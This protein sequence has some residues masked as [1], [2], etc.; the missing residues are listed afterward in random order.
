M[1][2]TKFIL[3][4]TLIATLSACGGRSSLRPVTFDGGARDGINTDARRDTLT[5]D[6]LRDGGGLDGNRTDGLV[7]DAVRDGIRN[8]LSQDRIR[9]DGSMPD[10]LQPDIVRIDARDSNPPEVSKTLV[11]IQATPS[12]AMLT[13]GVPFS[14]LVVTGIYSDGT[15]ADLS[16]GATFTSSDPKIVKVNGRTLTGMAVGSATITVRADGRTTSMQ[17]TVTTA[18]FQIITV[19]SVGSLMVGQSTQVIAMGVFA[20][21]TKQDITTSATWTSSN[22]AVARFAE[23]ISSA[24]RLDALSAGTTTITATYQSA[25]GQAQVTVT[26]SPLVRI[27]ITPTQPI[28]QRGVIRAFQATATFGDATTSDVT[29]Q[30]TWISSDPEVV[31]IT[32]SGNSVIASAIAVGTSTIAATLG[33]IRSTTDV[34]VTNPDLISITINPNVWQVNVGGT[35]SFTAQ[36]IYS[37]RT[38]ADVTLAAT[39]TSSA[40]NIVSVSNANGQQGQVSALA[41][42]TAQVQAALSGISG[43]AT[44]T[45]TNSPL[46]SI[47]ITP[48]PGS[49]V[50]GVPTRFSAIGNYQNGTS[51]PITSQVV[52]SVANGA[53]AS[54]SNT[55]GSEGSVTGLA[56]GNTT[57]TATLAGISGTASLTVVQANLI[58]IAVNP[59]TATLTAG[60]DQPYAAV[61]TYDNNT[62][63]DLTNQVTWSSTNIAVA[64]VSN[65]ATSRGLATSLIAGDTIISASLNGVTGTA[66]MTVTAP[67]VTAV[68]MT[69]SV[70]SIAVDGSQAFVVRAVYANGT[71]TTVTNQATFTSSDPSIATITTATGG[72]PGG[73]RGIATGVSAGTVTLTTAYQGFTDSATLTVRSPVTLAGLAISPTD[74]PAILVGA[75]Q[76]FQANAIYSD[77]STRQVTGATNW[78]SS[79]P[80]AA[81]IS[82]GG[83]G[84]RGQALGI[85]AGTTT[86]TAT[87]NGFTDT[88]TLTVRD[89]QPTGLVVTP[90]AT[91]L[92]VNQTQQYVAMLTLEDGTTRTVTNESSWTTSDGAIASITS[93]NARGGGSRGLA[94]GIGAGVATITAT[95]S[96]LTDTAQLTVTA[97]SAKQLIV[98]PP[99]PSM[100]VGSSAGFVATVVFDDN[101]TAIVTGQSTWSS[102][103]PAVA[104]VSSGGGGGI[105]TAIAI[106]KSTIT[107]TYSGLTGS[108]TLTV[109]DPEVAFVQVTPPQFTLP[110]NATTQLTATAVFADNTTRNVTGLAT[111]TSSQPTIALVSNSG[112][113][114]GQAIALTAGTTTIS[115]TYQGKSGSSVL[116]VADAILSVNIS[117]AT[118][119]SVIGLP[120]PFTATATLSNNSVITITNNVSWVSSD[121]TVATILSNGGNAGVA[122][123][124]K[125]GSVT[126][127]ATYLGT[128]STATLTIRNATL[129]SIVLTPAPVAV[130]VGSTLPMVATGTFSDGSTQVITN[131]VTWLSAD[132]AKATI[133]NA[134]GS[135]GIVTGLAVGTTTLTAIFQGISGTTQ[136][137]VGN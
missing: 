14:N 37:D 132:P 137:T 121:P 33:A 28:L 106:G 108:T 125:A 5:V 135:R 67:H 97:A 124:V 13:V 41:E 86:L 90:A 87:Y 92:R 24:P 49:L 114:R 84:A 18:P 89:P 26:A 100:P 58:S 11:S 60:S 81:S 36:A 30:A 16:A 62:T 130:Q 20:D 27:D 80:N 21:G 112:G 78:T 29:A 103:D 99:N 40:A 116:N 38:T 51:Q 75:I 77:G 9:I 34:T 3:V 128:S 56:L 42:G 2:R 64:Q 122:T 70:A 6:G 111:W 120:V 133:S 61:G 7:S 110:L 117:P 25:S 113:N 72:R 104:V 12:T 119:T 126:I 96:G 82:N 115:A 68:I 15:K 63:I 53:I 118:S 32:R 65:A 107:A 22:P 10:A 131:Q 45:V 57:I 93:G 95:F 31:R 136:V 1:N 83:G 134:F 19:E 79:N 88:A 101:T 73:G 109:N 8:D 98:T 69:P 39:W 54:V 47:A 4:C 48:N 91:N 74:P 123:P 94:T 17:I 23:E 76:G 85:G 127:T 35:Q 43:T 52:W 66:T 102:S 105:A 46:A 59:P 71:T 55:A 129:S 44:V 50:L